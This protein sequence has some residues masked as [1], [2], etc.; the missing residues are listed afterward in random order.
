MTELEDKYVIFLEARNNMKGKSPVRKKDL[1]W[2]VKSKEILWLVREH[3]A[4]SRFKSPL[5]PWLLNMWTAGD[6]LWTEK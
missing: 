5:D 1:L 2:S 6:I 4:L 3:W